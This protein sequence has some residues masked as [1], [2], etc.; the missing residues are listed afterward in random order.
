MSSIGEEYGNVIYENVLNYIDNVANIDLCKITALQ[1]MMKIVGVNY[2]VLDT[3]SHIPVE[4]ARI[5]DLLSIN[6]KYLLDSKTFKQSFIDALKSRNV[7]VP[8]KPNAFGLSSILSSTSYEPEVSAHVYDDG[9]CIDEQQYEKFLV[10]VYK[11]VLSCFVYL[12]YADAEAGLSVE[13]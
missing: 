3:F 5:M 2:D 13:H 9:Q 7:I 1:S 11:D 8:A 6:H 12:K 4:L 10:D